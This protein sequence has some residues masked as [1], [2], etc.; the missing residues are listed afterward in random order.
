M[1]SVRNGALAGG[2]ALNQSIDGF[3][4]P[5]ALQLPPTTAIAAGGAGPQSP[6][7]WHMASAASVVDRGGTQQGAWGQWAFDL[8][9]RRLSRGAR[10]LVYL[11]GS[12]R[13]EAHTLHDRTASVSCYTQHCWRR[14]G[15][16]VGRT[17]A[18]QGGGRQMAWTPRPPQKRA[19]SRG[20]A[21]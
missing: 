19:G 3:G 2:L 1:L 15:I 18:K 9:R 21:V 8:A 17:V 10:A 7:P 6:V 13:L 11:C 14:K 16:A 12:K 20:G 5:P 4:L